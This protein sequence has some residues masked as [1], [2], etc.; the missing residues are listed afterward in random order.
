LRFETSFSASSI[1]GKAQGVY[2]R[3]GRYAR[4][5]RPGSQRN[6]PS[7]VMK[8]ASSS[9]LTIFQ[10]RRRRPAD[11]MRV[12]DFGFWPMLSKKSPQKKCGIRI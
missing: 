10:A 8:C 6:L 9:E 5:G 3:L 7:R 4:R 2:L 11:R 1:A 12:A